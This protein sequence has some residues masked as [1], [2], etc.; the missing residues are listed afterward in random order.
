VKTRF[1]SG[2]PARRLIAIGVVLV[3]VAYLAY[4][5]I[6]KREVRETKPD[7]TELFQQ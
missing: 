1:V 2:D 5:F 6:A 7:V 4:R 3:G